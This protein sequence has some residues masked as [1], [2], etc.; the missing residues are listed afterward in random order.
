MTY[1]LVLCAIHDGTSALIFA[2]AKVVAM[3]T[4]A[5]PTLK[6]LADFLAVRC[7]PTILNA[8]QSVFSNIFIAADAK[9]VLF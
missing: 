1:G 6:T 2:K 7:R 8:F 5:F 9:I 3:K 4:K